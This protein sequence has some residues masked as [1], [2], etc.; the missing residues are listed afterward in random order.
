MRKDSIRDSGG[1]KSE[2]DDPFDI[3][4]FRVDGVVVQSEITRH[5]HEEL[6]LGL[7]VISLHIRHSIPVNGGLD[8]LIIGTRQNCQKTL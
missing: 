6:W 8:V 4:S 3:G 5:L 2:P 7:W 1:K